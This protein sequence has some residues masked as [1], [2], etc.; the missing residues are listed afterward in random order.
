LTWK[1]FVLAFRR[2]MRFFASAATSW[3]SMTAMPPV[4]LFRPRVA[5][6]MAAIWWEFPPTSRGNGHRHA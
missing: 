1:Y 2:L 3:R 5:V 6:G 4:S